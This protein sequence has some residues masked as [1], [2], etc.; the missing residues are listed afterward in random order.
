MRLIPANVAQMD[1]DEPHM[2]HYLSQ[3]SFYSQ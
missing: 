1:S 3:M 2:T